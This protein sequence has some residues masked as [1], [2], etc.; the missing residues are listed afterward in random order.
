[1]FYRNGSK[2]AFRAARFGGRTAKLLTSEGV[3]HLELSEI[4]KIDLPF[5]DPWDAYNDQLAVLCPDAT[6]RLVQIETAA[7]LSL[8]ASHARL[9]FVPTRS[10][11]VT[12]TTL[13]IVH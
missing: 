8:T 6:T 7:N 11:V 9:R 3:L 2:L 13:T 12:G 10:Q 5:H 4:A 1:M